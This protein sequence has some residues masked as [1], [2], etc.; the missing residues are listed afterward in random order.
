MC[1]EMEDRLKI[2][3]VFLDKM[4]DDQFTRNSNLKMVA[5]KLPLL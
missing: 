3:N 4:I 1:K 5:L 2:G